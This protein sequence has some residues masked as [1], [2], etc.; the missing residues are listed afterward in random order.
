M[1][2]SSRTSERRGRAGSYHLLPPHQM[3]KCQSQSAFPRTWPRKQARP[4]AAS[5]TFPPDSCAPLPNVG[6]W[7][8]AKPTVRTEKLQAAMDYAC[9]DGG[10]DCEGIGPGG[11]CYY[12]DNVVAHASYAS[13]RYWQKAKR[14]G[15]GCSFDG[16]AMLINSD[17]SLFVVNS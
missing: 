17:P 8:V 5:F 15:G 12:P 7:C 6:L 1:F 16:A 3:S 10:M 2:P 14:S 9:G 4:P 13:N 11:G